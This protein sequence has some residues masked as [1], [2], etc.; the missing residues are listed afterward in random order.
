MEQRWYKLYL[1]CAKC[2]QESPLGGRCECRRKAEPE[3]RLLWE[4]EF[5]DGQTKTYHDDNELVRD[6]QAG[7]IGFLAARADG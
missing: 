4:V 2:G 7:L 6:I 3:N 5:P 1:E